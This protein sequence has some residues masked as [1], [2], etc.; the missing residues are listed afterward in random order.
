MIDNLNT[1]ICEDSLLT[2]QERKDLVRSVA[3][4]GTMKARV[5][6]KKSTVPVASKPK[7]E[8]DQ[9]RKISDDIRQSCLTVSNYVQKNLII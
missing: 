8:K 3:A 6:L 1:L 7:E 4:I 9:Y 2:R 5:S